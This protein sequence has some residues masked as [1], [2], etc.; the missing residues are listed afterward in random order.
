MVNSAATLD[1]IRN[2]IRDIPNWPEPGVMFRDIS[3]LLQSPEAF[4]AVVDILV[5]RYRDKGVN[6]VAGLDARGFIFGPVVAYELGIGFVPIRK[7]GK[8][9]YTT[10]SKSYTLEYGDINTVEMHI[11]A[12]HRGEKVLVI[13]DLIATGG[14]MLAACSLIKELGAEVHE[15]AVV[16]DLLYL[17][18]SKLIREQGFDVFSILE[19]K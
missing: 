19:Y 16:S 2:S 12:V 3:T 14:T 11:D 5:E 17:N 1:M 10:V 7:K 6:V 9:P 15:C 4:R 13:D 18:G 8:L